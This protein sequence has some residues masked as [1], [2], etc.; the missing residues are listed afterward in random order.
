MAKLVDAVIHGLYLDKPL[1]LIGD[2]SAWGFTIQAL[3]GAGSQ[4]GEPA[5]LNNL[6]M[7]VAYIYIY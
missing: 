5:A 4:F 3:F 7:I 6:K 1:S 2:E